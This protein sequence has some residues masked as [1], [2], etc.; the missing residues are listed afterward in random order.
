MTSL[1]YHVLIIRLT[2]NQMLLGKVS[3]SQKIATGVIQNNYL[4]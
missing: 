4:G 1:H 3:L 2:E